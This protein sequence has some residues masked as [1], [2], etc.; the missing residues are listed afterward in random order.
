MLDGIVTY[1]TRRRKNNRR[2]MTPECI[3]EAERSEIRNTRLIHRTD[4]CNGPGSNCSKHI[5]V[6]LRCLDLLWNYLEHKLNFSKCNRNIKTKALSR[7]K[8]PCI[9]CL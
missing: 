4:K 6:H 8:G 2:R 1:P 7:R 3:K 5:C 9:I